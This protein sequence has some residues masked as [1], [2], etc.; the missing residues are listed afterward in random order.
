ML[1]VYDIHAARLTRIN[2]P[3]DVIDFTVSRRRRRTPQIDAD[4]A[5]D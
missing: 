4:G 5:R 3:D 2:N 1:N